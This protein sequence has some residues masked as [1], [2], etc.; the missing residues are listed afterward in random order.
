MTSYI[1]NAALSKTDGGAFT[2]VVP[3]MLALWTLPW[4]VFQFWTQSWSDL[5]IKNEP[6][7][8]R[9]TG[10]VQL[11]VPDPLQRDRDSELFA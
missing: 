3:G 8:D 1:D 10:T 4:T 6:E 11:P 9:D 5:L 2:E 7:T